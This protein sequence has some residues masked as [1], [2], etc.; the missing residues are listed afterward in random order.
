MEKGQIIEYQ[1]T[2]Y[3][4]KE[5]TDNAIAIGENEYQVLWVSKEWIYEQGFRATIGRVPAWVLL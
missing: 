4:I 1:G 3:K 5:I 2:Q